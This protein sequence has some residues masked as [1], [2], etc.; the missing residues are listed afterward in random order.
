MVPVAYLYGLRTV[1]ESIEHDVIG[2]FVRETLFNEIIPT[3]SLP[4]EDLEKFAGEVIERF[5]NPFVRHELISISLNSISKFTTRVL[6]SLLGYFEKQG[7][8]PKH[9]C[10]S[11]ACLIVFYRGNYNG[12]T[13]ALNDDQENL[14]FMADLWEKQ[15]SGKIDMAALTQSVLAKEDWWGQDLTQIPNLRDMVMSNIQSIMEEGVDPL[16]LSG[17]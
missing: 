5:Q 12:E 10:F 2:K 15:N 16:H 9:L 1:K 17:K 11:F 6:P 13:I 14:D 4:K 8:L 3:L 7:Q